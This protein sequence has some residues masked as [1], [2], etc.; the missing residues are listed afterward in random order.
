MVGH[1]E[2][3]EGPQVGDLLA[4]RG[5]RVGP[6]GLQPVEVGPEDILLG[7][8]VLDLLGQGRNLNGGVL[9]RLL[10]TF[11]SGPAAARAILPVAAPAEAASVSGWIARVA[12][13]WLERSWAPYL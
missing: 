3:V 2:G 10:Q 13:G 12:N 11:L 9:E 4:H 6:A 7:Q 1:R 8:P 5:R